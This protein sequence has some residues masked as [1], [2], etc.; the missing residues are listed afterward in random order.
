MVWKVE[1]NRIEDDVAF[2]ECIKNFRFRDI[3]GYK[4]I[5]RNF[6][7]RFFSYSYVSLV[8]ICCNCIPKFC[9]SAPYLIKTATA[10]LGW[11][12]ALI[13]SATATSAR[14]KSL[15]SGPSIR[16]L[17]TALQNICGY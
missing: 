16:R 17:P 15:S 3:F 9:T 4:S 7:N 10:P 2:V 6:C 5:I 8:S 12:A 11:F 1:L 13:L 14:E